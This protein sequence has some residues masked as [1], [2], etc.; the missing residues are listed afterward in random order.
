LPV[1]RRRRRLGGRDASAIRVEPGYPDLYAPRVAIHPEREPPAEDGSAQPT[2]Q[3]LLENVEQVVLGKHDE[4]ALVLAALVGGGHVLLEDVP[5]TAKTVLA[6]AIAQTIRGSSFAR[7]Q[8]TP[9]LQPTDVTGLS[10]FNQKTREFEFRPGPIFANI[11]LVDEINRAMPKTQS[12]LL[13][14]MAERQV[15]VDGVTRRLPEPF[16]VIATENPIEQ[17]GTFPLPEAQLDRFALRAEL[18]YPGGSEER[19]IVRAQRR[20]HPLGDLE[21]RVDADDVR[22]LHDAVEEVYVDELLLTWAV[23]LVRATREVEGVAVG[24]SVRGSLALERTA[25]A[26]ALVDGRSHVVPDDIDRLFVP[27]L[28]HRLLLTATFLAEMRALGRAEALREVKRRCLALAPPPTPNW[29]G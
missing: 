28:G 21:Q 27:V 5:G 17:E 23:D 26:W 14:A 25:R 6:R 7:I 24:A 29:D 8:C 15:T 12:A 4:V 19:E 20:G 11:V 9:D 1:R 3:A 2:A 18:G 13:E 10:I 22:A 16:L